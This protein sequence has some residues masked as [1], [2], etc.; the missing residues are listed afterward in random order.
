MESASPPPLRAPSRGAAAGLGLRYLQQVQ[1]PAGG[2]RGHGPSELPE[3][4]PGSPR[5]VAVGCTEALRQPPAAA[6]APGGPRRRRHRGRSQREGGSGC[7]HLREE[8]RER[9]GAR[10][11]EAESER[12][13]KPPRE[14]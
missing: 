2:T 14:K 11:G 6:H 7:G 4:G 3:R 9:R 12:R 1:A 5:R 10:E 13:E 8:G